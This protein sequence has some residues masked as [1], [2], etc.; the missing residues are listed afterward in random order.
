MDL[1]SALS[2][3]PVCTVTG[4]TSALGSHLTLLQK[5]RGQTPG[6]SQGNGKKLTRKRTC[7]RMLSF[8][9]N[10]QNGLYGCVD[11]KAEPLFVGS[12]EWKEGKGYKYMGTHKHVCAHTH[13]HNS[14]YLCAI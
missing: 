3:Q 11:D 14:S 8:V 9:Y 10:I 12:E 13:T 7:G 1:L 4:L 6:W 2:C 5:G